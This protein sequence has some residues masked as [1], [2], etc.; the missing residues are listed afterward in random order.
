ME[1]D[2]DDEVYI[3][4]LG[5]SFIVVGSTRSN[6][7]RYNRPS[8]LLVSTAAAVVALVWMLENTVCIIVLPRELWDDVII[9]I[10]LVV[11]VVVEYSLREFAH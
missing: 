9:I 6:S 7:L 4:V 1:D 5:S 11:V 3:T 8:P 10:V 2:E